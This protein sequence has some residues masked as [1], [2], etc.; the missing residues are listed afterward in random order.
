[1][2]QG[3]TGGQGYCTA[4][5]RRRD[6]RR[7]APPACQPRNA[8]NPTSHLRRATGPRGRAVGAGR[9]L[10]RAARHAPAVRGGGRGRRGAG[11]GR[12]GTCRPR[13]PA[14]GAA[15]R[16]IAAATESWPPC[17][18]RWRQKAGSWTRNGAGSGHARA[19]NWPLVSAFR[20]AAADCA[21]RGSACR[22]A[23]WGGGREGEAR[24]PPPALIRLARQHGGAGSL[25]H[26]S[27]GHSLRRAGGRPGTNRIL[28]RCLRSSMH[29]TPRRLGVP[30]ARRL[31]RRPRPSGYGA[32]GA[33]PGRLGPG[34]GRR[35]QRQRPQGMP[36]GGCAI[37]PPRRP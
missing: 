18:P 4:V 10:P 3:G 17:R 20:H 16:G 30:S 22:I 23:G 6:G 11:Q 29:A 13:R 8:R 9:S 24:A 5:G 2:R 19:S 7:R 28:V 12:A 37:L 15:M 25:L 27:F 14:R 35:Q 1:M 34:S 36:L 21:R 32:C 33:A 26:V 31:A